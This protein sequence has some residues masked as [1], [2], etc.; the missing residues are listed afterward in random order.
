M[1]GIYLKFM[2]SFI[3]LSIIITIILASQYFKFSKNNLVFGRV[4]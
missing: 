2:F 4:Y 3:N 1:Y